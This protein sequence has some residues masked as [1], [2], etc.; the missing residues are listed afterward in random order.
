SG[1]VGWAANES[2]PAHNRVA[3]IR[4]KVVCFI[5]W[6]FA[7]TIATSSFSDWATGSYPIQKTEASEPSGCIVAFCFIMAKKASP[8]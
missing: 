5:N 2:D 4:L 7:N 3:E 6:C 1:Q 8:S